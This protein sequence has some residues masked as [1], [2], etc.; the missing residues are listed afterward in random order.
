[1]KKLV[2]LFLI[3]LTTR[4]ADLTLGWTA[5]PSADETL[6]YRLY[7]AIGGSGTFSFYG[8]TT[9]LQLT[10]TNL[11]PGVYQFYATATNMWGE[12][13]PSN[14][15]KTPAGKPGAVTLFIVK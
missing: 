1:M 10:V 5:S 3:G 2:L 13:I 14:I 4:A 11:T 12:S 15:V 7:M 6:F 8:S 9:N